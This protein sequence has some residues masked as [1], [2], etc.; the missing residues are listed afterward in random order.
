MS[1]PIISVRDVRRSYGRGQNR[2][3]ALKGVSF[4]IQEGESV[5]IVGK[6]GSGKSTLM[7]LLA[8]LDAP[9][10]GVVELEGVDTSTLKGRRLDVTRNR[11]F[12]FVF[13]QFFLTPNASVLDNVVL[14]MKIAG[15]G[16]AERKRRGLAALAQLELDDKAGSR[17]VD[18]S[19]GQKQRTVIAR[20]L[21]NNPRIL[22]ADEP[23]G[24]L[25]TTTGGVVEDILFALNRENG[26]T[27]IVVT[28]DEELAAR[29]DRRLMIRDG[30]LVED[31]AAVAA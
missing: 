2:F 27:L 5:A 19:G 26:I 24:N 20:A 31:S 15:I 3:E 16:R 18:L 25:D 6:S 29:C 14:P 11:T 10:T 21:V 8:L 30:L 22:F 28:H 9:S 23:T 13:Q 7:H 17:A 4:D 12:G 1:T